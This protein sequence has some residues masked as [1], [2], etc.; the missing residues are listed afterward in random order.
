VDYADAVIAIEGR[1]SRLYQE[2][3][4]KGGFFCSISFS[5]VPHT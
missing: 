5:P 4:D 2:S 3:F 1:L